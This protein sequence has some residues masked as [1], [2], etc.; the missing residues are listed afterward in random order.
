VTDP[1]VSVRNN[2]SWHNHHENVRR[3]LARHIKVGNEKPGTATMSGMRSTAARLQGIIAE[4]VA[5]GIRLRVAGSRWSYSDIN[6]TD[7]CWLIETDQLGYMFFLKDSDMHPQSATKAEELILAQCGTKI[8]RLNEVLET[9]QRGR[10]LR[11]TGASNG[12]TIAGVLGTGVHGSAL[13]FGA[14]ENQ[15]AGLQLLSAGRNLWVERASDPVTSDDF[16]AK[17]GAELVR[18]DL[19]FSA[20]LVGLG[21]LG[22]VHAVLYRTA[23]RYL[24]NSILRHIPYAQARGA[25]TSMDFTNCGLPDALGQPYFFQGIID[26]NKPDMVY[27]TVRYQEDCPSSY[28]PKYDLPTASE[29]GTDLPK[30]VGKALKLFPDLRNL[31]VSTLIGSELKERSD[32]KEDWA[33]PGETYTFTTAREGVA[34][35][36]FAMPAAQVDQALGI[37]R[38]AFAEHKAAAVV[39]TCRFAQKSAGLLSFVR[40]DPC[41]IIDIDGIDTP[42]AR[43]LI[44][45]TADRF[46]AAGLD[47]TMHWG[48][49]NAINAARIAHGYGGD[50]ARWNQA[51]GLLLPAKAERNCFS[52][53][54][55]DGL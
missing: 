44:A 17:L 36:G 10:A 27:A 6:V 55:L 41:C 7:A 5:A 1:Y 53:P 19:L 35:S 21:A 49:M 23:P 32:K 48:K 29:P 12:Q 20:A 50:I 13:S 3:K 2:V 24:L 15:V 22:L 26:P 33:T 37:M 45:L 52:T 18:D 14:M 4:A 39:F 16:A 51:R 25:L 28:P 46:D 42:E 30:L 38:A 40:Y 31:A 9:P 54:F 34:S 11:T 8:S 43:K 47:Y